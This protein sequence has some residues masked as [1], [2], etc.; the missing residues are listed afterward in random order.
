MGG[1]VRVIVNPS[2]FWRESTF[3]SH[4]RSSLFVG[5]RSSRST[6]GSR[7]HWNRLDDPEGGV[8]CPTLEGVKEA[9]TRTEA[10]RE[11][12]S[13]DETMVATDLVR[14]TRTAEVSG[15]FD[16]EKLDS[17]SEP[18][19]ISD[20]NTAPCKHECIIIK[21]VRHAKKAHRVLSTI[22]PVK[23][24]LLRATAGQCGTDSASC[25]M[26]TVREVAG[27]DRLGRGN[28]GEDSRKASLFC[29]A[30]LRRFGMPL[31]FARLNAE[32]LPEMCSCCKA[33]LWDSAIPGS[34][35]DKIVAWQCHLGRCGGDGRQLQANEAVKRAMTDR[36]LS[37]VN[38]EERYSPLQASS[39]SLLISAVTNTGQ[40]TSWL[41]G[42][43][44]TVWTP[45]WT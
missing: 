12:L 18:R 7:K 6:F 17:V 26:D 9:M 4:H 1:R 40:G 29:A 19:L 28:H 33:P 41:S 13:E 30:T 11:P 38:P 39:S 44:S 45:Q 14:G 27:L 22:N 36:V 23:H 2:V 16:P 3:V 20:Y 25:T 21:Q 34:R 10:L 15:W 8:T 42:G 31:D 5:K 43:M 37:N 35:L 32:T 24:A